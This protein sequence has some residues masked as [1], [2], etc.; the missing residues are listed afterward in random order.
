MPGQLDQ[1]PLEARLARLAARQFGV[2]RRDQLERLGLVRGG[3]DRRV[4]AGRLHPV[5][6]GAY[7]VGVRRAA[8]AAARSA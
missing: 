6:R 3:I 1:D 4:Q 7:A 2:V 8:Q 5:H